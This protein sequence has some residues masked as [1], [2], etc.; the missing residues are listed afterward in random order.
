M[1]SAH[2]YQIANVLEW[3]DPVDHDFVD[4]P[5]ASTIFFELYYDTDCIY[6]YRDES[7]FNVRVSH[8]GLPLKFDTCLDANAKKGS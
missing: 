4:V 1:Y 3:L 8:N 6:K 5:Y 7:C 2:D